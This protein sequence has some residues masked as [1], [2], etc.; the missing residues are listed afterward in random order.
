MQNKFAEAPKVDK[1]IQEISEL[2]V[3]SEY[4]RTG[5]KIIQRNS[6]KINIE[7]VPQK[8]PKIK[9]EADIR[10][11]FLSGKTINFLV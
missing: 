11:D 1:I 7:E 5:K 4:D 10:A 9:S 6:P 8:T 3:K 2:Q